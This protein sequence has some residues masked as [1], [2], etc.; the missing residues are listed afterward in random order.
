MLLFVLITSL[1]GIASFYTDYLWFDSLGRAEVWRG[2]LGAKIALSVIFTG[3]FFL[4]MWLNL[5]IADRLAPAFRPAGPEEEFIERYH[6][7]VGGRLGLVRGVVSVLLAL[8]AGAG[9]SSEW[10]SWLLFTHSRDFGIDDP[11]F[12]TDIGFYVFRLPVPELPR[13]GGCSRRC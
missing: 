13:P 5:V 3:A 4:M 8:I 10:N 6:E 11:Q 9:V 1:R 2:V 7:L 12:G